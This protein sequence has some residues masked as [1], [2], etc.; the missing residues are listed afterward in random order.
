MV[1]DL[2][3]LEAAMASMERARADFEAAALLVGAELAE[4]Q[5]RVLNAH[6]AVQRERNKIEAE[7][8]KRRRLSG[9]QVGPLAAAGAANPDEQAELAFANRVV[10]AEERLQSARR[11]VA[12]LHNEV[13]R[14]RA[15]VNAAKASAGP[16]LAGGRLAGVREARNEGCSS[17]VRLL[18]RH[19]V[20]GKNH[21]V[22]LSQLSVLHLWRVREVSRHFNR[23]ATEALEGLPRL[24]SVSGGMLDCSSKVPNYI[25]GPEVEVLS[26]ATMRWSAAG[27]PPLPAP[28]AGHAV[29]AFG[30]GRL[31][32]AG[33]YNVGGADRMQQL[34]KQAVQWV[35][36][37]AAWAA[38]P[39]LSERRSGAVAV[40]LPDGRLLVAGGFD[41]LSQ[42]HA[43]AEVL[44]ADGSGWEVVASMSGPRLVAAAGLLPSGRV[45]LAGGKSD[46][47]SYTSA[48]ATAEQWDPVADRWSALPSMAVA[49]FAAAGTVLEDGRFA[50]VG[51][52][53]SD[54]KLRTDGAVFDPAT[55]RWEELSDIVNLRSHH[56]VVAV[57][58]GMVAIGGTGGHGAVTTALWEEEEEEEEAAAELFDEESGRWFELPHAMATSRSAIARMVSVPVSALV[59]PPP[60]AAAP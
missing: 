21:A 9:Q 37:S 10:D 32:V 47:D 41:A 49:R 58:G 43:S 48:L 17:L 33:G 53:G 52:A 5:D 6:S 27:V 45:I 46:A 4:L 39:D 11:A 34:R 57:A 1:V 26:L 8:R 28:R 42:L 60:V 56:A 12:R 18:G 51:G 59:G 55:G 50:V 24:V 40:A 15:G 36:G 30:D 2:T 35:P 29:A 14:T 16:L 22:V 20:G 44:A 3:A 38:L 19:D 25:N 54:G 13:Q 31:V 7:A 23:W